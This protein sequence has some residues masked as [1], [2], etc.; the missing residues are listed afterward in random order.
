MTTIYTGRTSA[1]IAGLIRSGVLTGKFET[2][3]Y[4]PPTRELGERYGVSPP[5]YKLE[6]MQ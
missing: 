5:K 3:K 4:I 2:G 6:P 1:D